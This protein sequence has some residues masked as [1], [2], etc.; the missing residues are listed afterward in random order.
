MAYGVENLSTSRG[1]PIELETI[2][3]P[4]TTGVNAHWGER[5][6]YPDLVDIVKGVYPDEKMQDSTGF[7][8]IWHQKNGTTREQ[9]INDEIEVGLMVLQSTIESN[10]WKPEEVRGLF[11][12]SGVPIADDPRYRD[13]ARVLAERAGLRPDTYLHNTYAACASGGH[14][15]INALTHPEMKGQK[16]VVIGMEGIS[17]LTADFN[18]ENADALSMTF[19]S[20]GASAIGVI[21]DETMTLLSRRHSVVRDEKGLLAAHMTYGDLIDPSGEQWQTYGNTDMIIMPQPNDGK[22]ISMQGPRTGLYFITNTLDLVRK[23]MLEHG[24]E[25]PEFKPDF[26]AQHHP[27]RAVFENFCGK[28]KKEGLDIPAPWV[29][30]DGNSSAATSLIAHNRITGEMAQPGS[31]ELF[32]TYGAGGS[33]DGGVLLHAGIPQKL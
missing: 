19:F 10:G 13:Y 22:K 20:N 31:V 26:I 15:L 23:L 4:F 1:T 6:A 7:D 21:P 32:V 18:P 2:S 14:E 3:G 29:V 17:H 11:L 27:S 12:G 25:F 33:F 16:V 28:A 30:K 24:A 9:G 5:I 8:V